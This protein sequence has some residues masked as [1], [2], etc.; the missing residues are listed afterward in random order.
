MK[1]FMEKKTTNPIKRL[2]QYLSIL[3]LPISVST[4]IAIQL[5]TDSA[6]ERKWSTVAYLPKNWVRVTAD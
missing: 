3:E 1:Y 5:K 6:A 2:G 4:S